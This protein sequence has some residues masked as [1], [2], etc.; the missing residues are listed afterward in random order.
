MTV[1]EGTQEIMYNNF[2]FLYMMKV[3]CIQH[4]HSL[5]LSTGR[6]IPSISGRYV[7]I[8]KEEDDGIPF[9]ENMERLASN[10]LKQQVMSNALNQQII[11]N[12]KSLGF[13]E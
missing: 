3:S 4:V 7:G 5:I 11:S 8:E 10:Y 1:Y 6:L 2:H 9:E 12:L 13:I